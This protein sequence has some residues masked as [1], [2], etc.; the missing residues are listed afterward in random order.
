MY[1]FAG[2]GASVCHWSEQL[3]GS[4][5]LQSVCGYNTQPLCCVQVQHKQLISF[6]A[7]QH[8][9]RVQ[10]HDTCSISVSCGV[11]VVAVVV[12]ATRVQGV[13]L[14]RTSLQPLCHFYS[15]SSLGGLILLEREGK[16]AF[17]WSCI[18]HNTGV[19]LTLGDIGTRSGG[20]EGGDPPQ[21]RRPLAAVCWH[22][23]LLEGSCKQM[24]GNQEFLS[25][26]VF[27]GCSLPDSCPESIAYSSVD[28]NESTLGCAIN[29]IHLLKHFNQWIQRQ[30]P[31]RV[32][33]Y[34]T[35][36]VSCL[37]NSH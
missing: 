19:N 7:M 22:L 27:C 4:H 37:E 21:N 25:N 36:D 6:M 35:T 20:W 5:V 14:I 30:T 31:D 34:F 11:N 26:F 10:G 28:S 3:C 23:A 2:K 13:A 9:S 8:I 15:G 18:I 33:L 16:K 29:H 24:L 1:H 32:G 17:T 12:G